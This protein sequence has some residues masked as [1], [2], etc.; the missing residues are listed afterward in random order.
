TNALVIACGLLFR[1]ELAAAWRRDPRG[2]LV[3][4]LGLG[5]FTVAACLR[6]VIPQFLA[7][8]SQADVSLLG[9]IP[10]VLGLYAETMDGRWMYFRVTERALT[11]LGVTSYLVAG[12]L[13][14][15][16]LALCAA[17]ALA[18][19]RAGGVTHLP[20]K[21]RILGCHLLIFLMISLEV[22]FTK[23]AWGAHHV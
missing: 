16:L 11:A 6:L 2:F 21:S 15:A 8:Q 18:A 19:R 22:W 14:G 5:L 9:R 7:S 23:K 1:C 17:G 4:L 10:Y 12:A 20:L 13:A 3:P